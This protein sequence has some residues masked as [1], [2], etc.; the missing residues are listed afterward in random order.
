MY[1]KSNFVDS[2]F[3]FFWYFLT[4]SRRLVFSFFFFPFFF[5]FYN[6]ITN[7][8]EKIYIMTAGKKNNRQ[9]IDDI[10]Q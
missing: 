5:F 1:I 7:S 2:L 3:P 10:N 4:F 8:I 9:E 6:N